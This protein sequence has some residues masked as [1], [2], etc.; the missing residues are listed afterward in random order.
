LLCPACAVPVSDPR[1]PHEACG[2]GRLFRSRKPAPPP[3]LHGRRRPRASSHRKV[4]KWSPAA[5]GSPP[6]I[7]RQLREDRSAHWHWVAPC[8]SRFA[9]S[10]NCGLIGPWEREVFRG[11]GRN[12][13]AAAATSS[14]DL[15][16]ARADVGCSRLARPA[17]EA[18]TRAG[19]TR[20]LFTRRGL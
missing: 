10:R 17:M 15:R 3:A 14:S 1:E 16:P 4:R 13:W 12:R 5:H 11:P 18:G 2:R 20:A 8:Q 6:K 19:G 7:K 9:V